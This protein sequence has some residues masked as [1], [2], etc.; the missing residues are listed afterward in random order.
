MYYTSIEFQNELNKFS[1]NISKN[2]IIDW[3]NKLKNVDY[4][5]KTSDNPRLWLEIHLTSLLE[6][7]INQTII[8]KRELINKQLISFFHIHSVISKTQKFNRV[9]AH[10]FR[11]LQLILTT[12]LLISI[13][14]VSRSTNGVSYVPIIPNFELERHLQKSFKSTP[15]NILW[16]ALCAYLSEN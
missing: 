15:F 9:Y 1:Y 13:F 4:Q 5:I 7:N 12:C 14:L 10:I 8:N 11:L 3:H 6:E 16:W 2:R